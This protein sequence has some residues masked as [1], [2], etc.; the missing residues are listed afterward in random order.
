L[1]LHS[2]RPILRVTAKKPEPPKPKTWTIYKIGAEAVR[3]G[4]VEAPDEAAAIEKGAA[5]FKVPA[6]RL[7]ALRR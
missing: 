3:L 6:T 5:E 2:S 1:N 4:T 7:M